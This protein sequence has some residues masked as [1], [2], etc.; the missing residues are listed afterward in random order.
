MGALQRWFRV[1]LSRRVQEVPRDRDVELGLPEDVQ[2]YADW[3]TAGV[4]AVAAALRDTDPGAAMWIRGADP[5]ARS[6][7]RRMLFET[8]VHRVDVECAVGRDAD[9]APELAADGVD[10]F[11]VNLPYAELF[12]PRVTELRGDG[13]VLVFGCTDAGGAAGEE[14]RV[15]LEPDGFRPVAGAGSGPG[16]RTPRP[17]GLRPRTSCCSTAAG[18]QGAVLR[19]VGG[20]RTP[21][22]L[23]GTHGV[24]TRAPCPA[25][26]GRCSSGLRR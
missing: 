4:P 5:H 9:V 17:S 14:W 25:F 10:E 8:L 26:D 15:R 7:V 23:V 18:P 12:A 2:D 13:E 6:W 22:P 21:E 1:L 20:H 3:L 19:G 11:L 24:L 16:R